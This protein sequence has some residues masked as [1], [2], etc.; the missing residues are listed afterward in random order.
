VR[1]HKY[2][3]V[4][5]EACSYRAKRLECAVFPRFALAEPT[6]EQTFSESSGA[7]HKAREYRALQTLRAQARQP[8][9]TIRH[10]TYDLE[11]LAGQARRLPHYLNSQ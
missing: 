1:G 10:R 9:A 6:V 3:D 8:R 5:A 4:Q 2:G 11:H 7:G